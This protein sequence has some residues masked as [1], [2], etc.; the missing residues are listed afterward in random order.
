MVSIFPGFK[1]FVM[2]VE[3]ICFSFALSVHSHYKAF[4]LYYYVLL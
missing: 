3:T 4:K 1:A 2:F